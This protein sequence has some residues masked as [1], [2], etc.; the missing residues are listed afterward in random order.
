MTNG[1]ETKDYA[2]TIDFAKHIAMMAR[3]NKSHEYRNYFIN[4]EKIA[5]EII[6]NRG[7]LIDT[8]HEKFHKEINVAEKMLK[9]GVIDKQGMIDYIIDASVK[10]GYDPDKIG[11]SRTRDKYILD[12]YDKENSGRVIKEGERETDFIKWINDNPITEPTYLAKIYFYYDKWR[13]LNNSS[14]LSRVI[15]ARF[16]RVN[17]YTSM[18]SNIGVYFLPNS[19]VV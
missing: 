4:C 11:L 6:V 13:K 9:K 14:K 12:N 2:V 18:R 3:T 19:L 15:L 1:N 10:C 8:N 5:K 16:L 17:G 7:K